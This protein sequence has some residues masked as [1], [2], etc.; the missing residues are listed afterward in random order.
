MSDNSFEFNLYYI[1]NSNNI[2]NESLF[3]KYEPLSFNL[4]ENIELF[5][6]GNIFEERT[7][8]YNFENNYNYNQNIVNESPIKESLKIENNS[9]FKTQET[10]LIEGKKSTQNEA[11]KNLLESK[12][13]DN[14]KLLNKK[15]KNKSKNSSNGEKHSKFSSDNT[16]RKIKHITLEN[17]KNLINEK[18]KEIYNNNIGLGISKK[19]LLTLNQS[20]KVD[21]TI[22]FNKQFIDKKL[23]EIFSDKISTRYTS[24][25]GDFNKNLIKNLMNEKDLN[26]REYFQK[27]FNLSFLDCLSHFRGSKNIKELTG[28]KSFSEY[29][30]EEENDEYYKNQLEYYINDFENI[31]Q[32]KRSRKRR[33]NGQNKGDQESQEELV[34]SIMIDRIC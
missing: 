10:T 18:I 6:N 1:N 8:L 2:S 19:K 5:N 13:K 24:Y 17:V 3:N 14:D 7:T 34:K 16:L 12:A 33:E 28:L 26:K 30:N 11:N 25:P 31:L 9:N 23:Y 27:L 29:I 21:A 20:Q 32:K 15:R 4:D 22:D